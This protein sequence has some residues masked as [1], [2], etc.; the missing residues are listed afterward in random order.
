MKRTMI[1]FLSLVLAFCMAAPAMAQITAEEWTMPIVEEK[2]NLTGY[3]LQS[4]QGGDAND[5]IAW[6]YY[7]ELTNIHIEWTNV[8]NDNQD[9]VLSVMLASGDLPDII[10]ACGFTSNE[11]IN[12]GSTG[13]F[14]DLTEAYDKYAYNLQKIVEENP[15]VKAAITSADG[16]IYGLPHIK[17]GDNMRTNK[18]FVNP[19]WLEAVNLEMPTNFE[20]FEA[21]LYAFRDNDANGDGDP[22]NEIPYIIRYN[23]YHFL[24]SLY[25]FFGLGNR[26]DGHRY[27]DWDYENNCLRFIPTTSQFKDLLT[28]AHK[29]YADGLIDV[30]TFQNTSSKQIVAKTTQNLVGVHSDFVTNTGS[31]Y[32]EIFRCIPVMENYYGEKL[33]TRRSPL[34]ASPGA[35]VVSAECEYIDELVKWADY[36]Y[37]D[38]GAILYNMGVEGVTF[39]YDENGVPQFKDE[40]IN[41]PEGLTLTQMRVK[42]MGFQ[43]GPGYWSDDTYKGA[44]TYWTSTELMDDYRQYLPEEIWE[45]FNATYEEAE[46]MD[47]LFTDIQSYLNENI[48]AFI[49]GSRSLD[50]WDDYVATIESMGLADYMAL[51]Q[52]LYE[53]Y[54]ASM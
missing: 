32:Q 42:Y 23:D 43:S 52:T 2:I 37:S 47:Y 4:P 19:D 28:V 24:P 5:M 46:Q 14:A 1:V 22:N 45:S 3:A 20:E 16:K 39:E 36:F 25:T 33:W 31:V 35:F 41:N 38:E 50:E 40:L 18:I 21:M 8:P 15:S 49:T 44:E 12:Y 17:L 48:A 53:R 10:Y 9:E 26:G 13:L 51:Y 6:D 54:E 11:L 7:E 30:E 27:V 29:W 34:I